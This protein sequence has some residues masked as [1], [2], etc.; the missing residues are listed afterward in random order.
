MSCRGSNTPPSTGSGSGTPCDP[1]HET[2]PP[3]PIR[4]EIVD[5]KTGNVISGTTVNRIV[6]QKIE[7]LVR[8]QPAEA[9]S[10]IQ[11]AV[12]GER[13]KDYTQTNNTGTVTQL[14]PADLQ[15]ANLDF[16]WKAGG[17][18]VVQVSATARGSALSASATFRVLAP[19]GLAM[20]SVTGTVE[21]SNPGFP[22]SG[23]ELHFGTNAVS[24]IV[25][26]FTATAPAGGTGQFVGTQ[27]VSPHG[28]RTRN[29][30]TVQTR[31]SA[32]VFQLDNTIQYDAPVAVAASASATWTSNDSPGSPL[33]A[34]LRDNTQSRQ[35]R[36]YFMYRPDGADSIWVTIGRLDWNWAGR[37]TRTCAAG[38]GGWCAASGVANSNNPAGAAS[39]ELPEWTANVSTLQWLP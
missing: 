18:Q 2:C 11:W 31:S 34:D 26:T 29:D 14:Q 39:T 25:W 35:Y 30:G 17:N 7:L 36:T 24:G 3:P 6:G 20:T 13:I 5:R 32:G 10:N 33:T 8:T 22:G 19:T 37:S 1:T 28:T 16:Y 21:V 12:P 9:M 4:L 23:L 15:G 38:P 27:T